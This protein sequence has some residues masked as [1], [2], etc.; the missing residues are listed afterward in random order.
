[1]YNSLPRHTSPSQFDTIQTFNLYLSERLA[2]PSGKQRKYAYHIH[3]FRGCSRDPVCLGRLWLWLSKM[4]LTRTQALTWLTSFS[5][6]SFSFHFSLSPSLFFLS[7]NLDFNV[8]WLFRECWGRPLLNAVTECAS[9]FVH[10]N[11]SISEP[12]SV[13]SLFFTLAIQP[14]K[15]LS[16]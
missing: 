11:A 1:M 4:R 13:K 9:C 10:E 5:F 8:H 6:L 15:L 7:S 3:I 12:Q 16:H 14:A 2:Y